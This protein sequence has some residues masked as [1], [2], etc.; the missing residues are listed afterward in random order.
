VEDR[1]DSLVLRPI[2]DD[3]IGAAMGSLAG[4]GPSTDAL[5]AMLREEE[6]L[7]EERRYSRR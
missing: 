7:T 1:G 4:Q 3:P 5:R 6:V 2:P